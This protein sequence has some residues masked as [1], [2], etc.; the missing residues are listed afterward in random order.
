MIRCG[1]LESRKKLEATKRK[2]GFKLKYIKHCRCT[3][4]MC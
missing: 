3:G 1:R 4:L 2:D